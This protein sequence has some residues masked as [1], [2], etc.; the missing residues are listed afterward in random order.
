[1][2]QNNPAI[3]EADLRAYDKASGLPSNLVTMAISLEN[4]LAHERAL[5]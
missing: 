5:I 2:A 3:L 1:M 4:D